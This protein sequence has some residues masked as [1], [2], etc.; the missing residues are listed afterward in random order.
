MT[1]D[2][3]HSKGKIDFSSKELGHQGSIKNQFLQHLK[4]SL[5]KDA[6]TVKPWDIYFA[7]SLSLR[8]RLIDRWLKT[9]EEYSRRDVKKVHYLSMEFLIGRLLSNA[10]INLNVYDECYTMLK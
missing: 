10:L 2:N 6:N 8:D 3:K 9:Q 5:I 4:Y 1:T 7:L